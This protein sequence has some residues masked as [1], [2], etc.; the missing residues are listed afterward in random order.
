MKIAIISGSPRKSSKTILVINHAYNYLKNQSHNLDLIDLADKN[1]EMY[2][3]FDVDYNQTTKELIKKLTEAD[4]W[5]IGTPV[6]NSFFSSAIKNVFEY[7]NYKN[8]AGKIAGLIIVASGHISFKSVQTN[9]TQLMSYFGV[10]TN[11]NTAYITV[12][13]I[14]EN[15]RLKKELSLRLENV[16]DEA[17][18]LFEVKG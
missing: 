5:I 14:D 4:I 9:L 7:I 3:G 13:E 1:I 6:Y 2:R 15:N 16:L 8:T 17:I 10:L 11:P 18:N 12:D